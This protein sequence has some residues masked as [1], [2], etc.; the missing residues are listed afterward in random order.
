MVGFDSS[1]KFLI[2]AGGGSTPRL[3]GTPNSV[4]DPTKRTGARVGVTDTNVCLF[5]YL[6]IAS[7]LGVEG[8]D[9]D[10]GSCGT[11]QCYR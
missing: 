8:R 1:C 2:G 6:F 5:I 9:S 10:G 7:V 11:Q 3:T 4:L